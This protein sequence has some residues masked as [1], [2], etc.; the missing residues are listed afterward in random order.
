[1]IG[2]V[3][4]APKFLSYILNMCDTCSIYNGRGETYRAGTRV[5]A[6]KI[7]RMMHAPHSHI[8]RLSLIQAQLRRRT[9]ASQR[10]VPSAA[11][12]TA[13]PVAA[14]GPG[15]MVLAHFNDYLGG[16]SGISHGAAGV[17]SAHKLSP[18]SMRSW[19]L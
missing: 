1:M 7:T 3:F 19:P 12:T 15:H 16:E 4:L 2:C 11:A 5:D 14:V 9:G 13:P 18:I 8:A 17:N 6:V 10:A